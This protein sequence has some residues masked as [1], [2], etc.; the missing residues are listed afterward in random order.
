MIELL[1]ELGRFT[2]LA[3][4][5]VHFSASKKFEKYIRLFIANV[6]MVIIMTPI[7][8][9]VMML[10][11]ESAYVFTERVENI[12][13]SY[14]KEEEILY[15]LSIFEEL[16]LEESQW[17]DWYELELEEDSSEQK[18]LSNITIEPIKITV[19]Y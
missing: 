11:G 6:T 7:L 18:E 1:K 14:W 12:M 19:G 17:N 8:D 10:Q 16:E 15:E 13:E 5:L 3:Q 2:I 9:V 4:I